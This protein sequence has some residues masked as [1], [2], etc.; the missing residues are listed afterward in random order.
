MSFGSTP[1]K[2]TAAP[3]YRV[4]ALG[5][6]RRSMGRRTVLTAV[7][8]TV[9]LLVLTPL[10]RTPQKKLLQW[11]WDEP[12]TAYLR[13]HLRE[14]ERSPFDGCVFGV[15]FGPDGSGGSFS[16]QFWGRRRFAQEELAGAFA[17]LRTLQPRRFS[18]NFLRIN[19][20]PGDLDWFDD[21]TPVVENA[22]LAARMARAGRARGV[23]LDVE[24]YQHRLFD[25]A[26]Q[27]SAPARGWEAYAAQARLRGQEL[28]TAFQDSYPDLSVFLTFGYTLPWVLSEEGRRPLA[29]TPY[30]LLAPFL[31]GML[32]GARGRT[33][34]VDGFELSYGFKE[35]VHFADAR[36]MFEMRVLPVVG[37]PDVYFRRFRL[38]FG[39]WLDYDWRRLGWSSTAVKWNYFSPAAFEMALGVALRETDE[40]VWVYA[41]TPR[42]WDRPES[43]ARVPNAYVS[44]LRL[45]QSHGSASS[46]AT[47]R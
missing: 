14:M 27:A 37:A 2:D 33:R 22:R 35:A 5:W 13:E 9:G 21:F 1:G 36:Q 31:D 16:W 4:H 20:T 24:Q 29:E 45:A 32:E 38:A 11:G 46:R 43:S 23:L 15:R 18:D 42:W 8:V 12:D 10:G 30:G 39:L 47:N 25:Y 17:D 40:Y 19:V 28:M 26:A 3:R 7:A 34:L 6:P 41:E 44:A